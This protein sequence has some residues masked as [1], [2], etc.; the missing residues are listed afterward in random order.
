MQEE[1]TINRR[2]TPINWLTVLFMLSFHVGA[3]IALFNFSWLGLGVA[4]F[5]WWFTGSLGIGIGYHRLL[6][7]RGFKTSKPV[8]YFL[9]LCGALALLGGP[10]AWVGKHRIHHANADSDRDPHSPRHGFWWSYI[11]WIITGK[12]DH[13]QIESL[14]LHTPDLAKD[15]FH[16]WISRWFFVPQFFLIAVLYWAGGW[17]LLLWGVCLRSVLLWHAAFLGVAFGHISGRR[18]F[19]TPDDSHNNWWVALLTFGEG[20]H[21]NHHASPSAARHGLVWYELDV[22]WYGIWTME[23][24]GLAREVRLAK[25]L[26]K[27]AE[28]EA[29]DHRPIKPNRRTKFMF[30]TKRL[31]TISLCALLCALA[32]LAQD[33]KAESKTNNTIAQD[34]TIII[35][36]Q[37]VRFVAQKAI[38]EMRLQVFNQAG[39]A[40]FDS[41][42]VTVNEINWPFKSIYDETIKSGLY[43]YTL[44]IKEMGSAK[45]RERRGHFIIDRAQDRDGADKLWVTSRNDNNVG[46]DLTVARDENA[47]VAG[48]TSAGQRSANQ[49]S[50]G[51]QGGSS[52]RGGEREVEQDAQSKAS[53]AAAAAGTIGRIAKF[54]SATN[55]DDSVITEQNGA[56]GIGVTNPFARLQVASGG[57]GATSYTARFQ[58]SPSVAGAGGIL[59]DQNSTYGWKVHT[60]GTAFTSGTLNFNYVNVSSGTSLTANPL[61][62]TGSGRV[63]IGTNTPVSPLEI[64]GFAP[65]ITLRDVRANSSRHAYIQN[66]EGNIVFKANSDDA[67]VV[68]TPAGRIGIGTS[69]PVSPLEIAGFAPVITLRDVR[70]NSARHA[71]IQNA[72]GNIVFKANSDN[73]HVVIAPAGNVGI[74]TSSPDPARKLEIVGSGATAAGI[75]SVNDRAFLS[76]TS[77]INGQDRTWSVESG[78]YGQQDTFGIFNWQ[79]GKAVLVD[80][81]GLL[82]ANALQIAGGADF[83]EHFD[84]KAPAALKIEA[85]MIVSIDPRNPGK[86]TLSARAYDRRV[87]GVIS[88]AGGVKPGVTMGQEGTLADGQHPVAL[89]G[90]V[91][92]WADASRGAIKP[93]DLLTT[94]PTPGHA[95][96]AANPSKAQGAIIGK[97]M[98]GLK[99]GKGLVLALVSLQ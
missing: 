40:V 19:E 13:L 8:E 64:A 43:A 27:S 91:Y 24:L 57:D 83:A 25:P 3:V 6:T 90:R 2:N 17:Q 20:W 89:S 46:I 76:L 81:S 96:K 32:A 69:T 97:A 70:A 61:V 87:A 58:S 4:L 47:T 62:L 11:G 74:G 31:I 78:V 92:V 80:P 35:Q 55:L 82:T 93:G 71:Y 30:L 14:A 10:I 36:Q 98:T 39:E 1:V 79:T 45:A 37:Q 68:I 41:G 63:G 66:A 34:V 18:R 7:H 42:P 38:D 59:F 75:K 29:P 23:K 26:K 28:P 12:S 99:R 73:A 94:S 49:Q 48:T 67:H 56:I 50:V 54:T 65:F 21:N 53:T 72:D 5:L 44:S 95:M 60:E 15:R 9:T 51:Q 84:V 33:R 77:K 16:L 22:N 85:G 52:N 86:L 88:G